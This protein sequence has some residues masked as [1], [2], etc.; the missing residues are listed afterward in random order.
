MRDFSA[1]DGRKYDFPKDYRAAYKKAKRPAD[2]SE[3]R[4]KQR[5]ERARCSGQR[6][7]LGM[8]SAKGNVDG[9]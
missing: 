2:D 7:A 6:V 4:V 8:R 1:F 9:E 5:R 3:R